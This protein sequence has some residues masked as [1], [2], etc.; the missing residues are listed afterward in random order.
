MKN[1]LHLGKKD[2]QTFRILLGDLSNLSLQ[3]Q[4]INANVYT[5]SYIVFFSSENKNLFKNLNTLNY[6]LY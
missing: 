2:K 3:P 1:N 5:L 6:H 4:C